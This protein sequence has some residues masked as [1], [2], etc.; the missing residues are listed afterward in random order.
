MSHSKFLS[1]E[2]I[3]EMGPVDG[4]APDPYV[5]IFWCVSKVCGFIGESFLA[6]SKAADK[7]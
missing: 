6:V 1:L 7:Y 2:D 4:P 3:A 5:G